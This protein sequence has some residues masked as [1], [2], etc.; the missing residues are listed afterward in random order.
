MALPPVR[1]CERRAAGALADFAGSAHFPKSLTLRRRVQTPSG[2][3][4]SVRGD[5]K[6]RQ[7][8]LRGAWWLGPGLG[9]CV[10]LLGACLVTAGAL[11]EAGSTGQEGGVAPPSSAGPF[12][13]GSDVGTVR[14]WHVLLLL[15]FVWRAWSTLALSARLDRGIRKSAA[16]CTGAMDLGLWLAMGVAGSALTLGTS[17]TPRSL[18]AGAVTLSATMS[19]YSLARLVCLAV[20]S[21]F[22]DATWMMIDMFRKKLPLPQF[23]DLDAGLCVADVRSGWHLVKT[24]PTPSYGQEWIRQVRGLIL[25]VLQ[26]NNEAELCELGF[27]GNWAG[28][29]LVFQ[30]VDAAVTGNRDVNSGKLWAMISGDPKKMFSLMANYDGFLRSGN[31]LKIKSNDCTITKD[32]HGVSIA[33]KFAWFS[34]V[35]L[36]AGRGAWT[37]LNRRGMIAAVVSFLLC[38]LPP[39]VGIDKFVIDPD[40]LVEQACL[41]VPLLMIWPMGVLTGFNMFWMQMEGYSPKGLYWLVWFVFHIGGN[42][43]LYEWWGMFVVI[44]FL[45]SVVFCMPPVLWKCRQIWRVVAGG[46]ETS[47]GGNLEI[48]LD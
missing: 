39:A 25:C 35:S 7:H 13:G 43:V 47:T 14:S 15:L 26:S 44:P 30:Q 36:H 46:C 17:G 21:L 34:L 16:L 48:E 20:C 11:V 32:S 22:R 24:I 6:R 8:F 33:N 10:F 18:F 4:G 45:I 19:A 31:Q 37:K 3:M 29:S 1:G 42:I 38:G 27:A 28:T 41:Y 5:R 2:R 9:C 12:V 40:D 23:G